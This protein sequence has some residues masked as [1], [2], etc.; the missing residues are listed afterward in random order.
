M[1]EGILIVLELVILAATTS[2]YL[3]ARR[4]AASAVATQKNVDEL[5]QELQATS[6]IVINDL[7]ART[8]TLRTLVEQADGR[9]RTLESAKKPAPTR[10]Q[11]IQPPTPVRNS[12]SGKPSGTARRDRVDNPLAGRANSSGD[13]VLRLAQQGLDVADIAQQL[14]LSREEV[15]MI[16]NAQSANTPSGIAP[17]GITPLV[18]APS[19][20]ALSSHTSHRSSM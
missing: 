7:N 3:L 19:G 20:N 12:P 10:I 6:E 11:V 13:A 17:T 15:T 2:I 9:R 18:K 5:L 4:T 1:F 8:A 14:R 16:L